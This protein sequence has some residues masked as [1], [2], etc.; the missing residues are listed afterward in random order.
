MLPVFSADPQ[1]QAAFQR[2][3]ELFGAGQWWEAHEAWEE[4]WARAQGQERDFLQA[5]ILLAAALHKRWHHGSTAHRNLYKADAYLARLPRVYA[6][7]DLGALREDVWA[8]LHDPAR[9]PQVLPAD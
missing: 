1:V 9:R 7:V 4:P 6:G 3:A 5:L 2:G 8:A